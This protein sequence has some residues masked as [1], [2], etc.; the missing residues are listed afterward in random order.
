VA[1]ERCKDVV[2]DSLGCQI[3]CS[4]LP[5]GRKVIDFARRQNGPPDA[6]VFG[7]RLRTSAE[8]AALVNGTLAHGD[9]IDDTIAPFGHA[10]AVVVPTALAVGEREKCSGKDVIAAIAVG[11]DVAQ[12]LA[13]AGFSSDVL[14]PRNFQQGS[15]AGSLAAAAIAGRLLDLDQEQMQAA[16]GLA[17]EQ[18]CGLQA[19]RGESNHENKSVHY[20]VGARNGVVA[21]Y[22]AQSGY[23]G[24]SDILDP[25]RSLFEAFVGEQARPE[26]TTAD[27][28]DRFS[29]VEVAFK[30]YACGRP[31]HTALEVLFGL[32]AEHQLTAGDLEAIEVRLPTMKHRLLSASNTLN[33]NIEY[34]I[35]VAALD[36]EV[37]W[38]QYT[39]A[40]QADPVLQDLRSRTSAAPDPALDLED[41]A[42][43]A[44][45]AAVTLHTRDG[46][47]LEGQMTFP[48]GHPR[49]PMPSGEL[50]EKF[51][52]W[53][54]RAISTAGAKDT[55]AVIARMD[56]LT[57][58]N[59]IGESIRAAV[60]DGSVSR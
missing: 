21:A 41:I 49:N 57:D 5:L 24:V 33:I 18:A 31:M 52:Y 43:G 58:V 10:G 4:Q 14:A 34:V 40:R 23:G 54:G 30:R 13:R 19:M 3:A 6:T 11:Y 22:L 32:M 46:R 60:G 45:P 2:L 44:F 50:E 28:G 39:E 15:T 36:G 42:H 9:E 55:A 56:E 51:V 7:T 59:A 38:G 53:A 8:H 16:L 26:E 17:G 35:A 20:G 47:V 1:V 48:L 29:I 25:P 37:T 27:L 12:R